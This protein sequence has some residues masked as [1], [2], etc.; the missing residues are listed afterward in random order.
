MMQARMNTEW[1]AVRAQEHQCA[2]CV[3]VNNHSLTSFVPLTAHSERSRLLLLETAIQ[4]QQ[5]HTLCFD[6]VGCA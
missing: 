2:L 4:T 6:L 5:R 3:S 1:T